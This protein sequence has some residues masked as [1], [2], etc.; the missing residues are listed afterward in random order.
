MAL[1]LIRTKDCT[2]SGVRIALLLVVSST[3]PTLSVVKLGRV[4]HA[5]SPF[6]ARKGSCINI[7]FFFRK[8]KLEQ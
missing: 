8:Q 2:T 6:Q 1:R 4:V 5:A 3:S 7:F